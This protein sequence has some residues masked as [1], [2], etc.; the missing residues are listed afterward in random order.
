MA[1]SMTGFGRAQR[2]TQRYAIE[3]EIRSLNNRYLKVRVHAG[4]LI[5]AL[6]GEIENLVRRRLSRGTVDVWINVTDVAPAG[7]Y[8]LNMDVA[9]RYKE[10]AA[11]LAGQLD[12]AGAP[13]LAEY[14]M[15]PGVVSTEG[16]DAEALEELR[17]IVEALMEEALGALDGMRDQEGRAL[18][19]D[20]RRRARV[21]ADLTE[22]IA[23]MSGDVVAAYRDRLLARVNELMSGSGVQIAAEDIMR[24]VSVFAERSD[25][26]EELARIESHLRQLE[27]TLDGGG[28]IG[29]KLEFVAQ[30]L[31]REINT[32]GSKA[33]D[34]GVSRLAVEAKVEIDKIK[35]QTQNLE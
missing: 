35:E 9:R 18:A 24:E 31:H 22:K 30:E 5:S 29:R 3:V 25:I 6:E 8:R 32:I 26:S 33:N 14:L 28:D 4:A 10:F 11:E 7:A 15:L 13:G 16:D 27:E 17:R 1:R 19:E 21:L 2:A 12:V 23:A 20:V 34:A